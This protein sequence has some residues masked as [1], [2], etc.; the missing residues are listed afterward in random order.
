M[1]IVFLILVALVSTQ[2]Y[3]GVLDEKKEAKENER[4]CIQ[5]QVLGKFEEVI[6][7][8]ERFGNDYHE[9]LLNFANMM[10]K[11]MNADV[12]SDLKPY[13]IYG[14]SNICKS[15]SPLGRFLGRIVINRFL[16]PKFML[17][18]PSKIPEIC[19]TQLEVAMSMSE[20]REF[21]EKC[22]NIRMNTE[23]ETFRKNKVKEAING[24]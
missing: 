17:T 22:R 14:T 5:D 6:C 2:Y 15:K 21:A 11:L 24:N 9:S 20:V 12:Q 1:C 23:I 16:E 4:R 3:L 8:S 19:D 7:E 13:D 18:A 10:E